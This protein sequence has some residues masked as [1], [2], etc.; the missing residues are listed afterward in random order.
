MEL[1]LWHGGMGR[2]QYESNFMFE[3]VKLV[4]V[5]VFDQGPRDVSNTRSQLKTRSRYF[6]VASLDKL[7]HSDPFWRGYVLDGGRCWACADHCTSLQT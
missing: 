4:L 1:G 3:Y 5:N 6:A 2:N 7:T